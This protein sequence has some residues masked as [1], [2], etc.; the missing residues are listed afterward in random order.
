MDQ[1]PDIQ[2]GQRIHVSGN[3]ALVSKIYP[4]TAD[5][6]NTVEI[7]Y[8]LHGSKPTYEDAHWIDGEWRFV[9]AGQV[10][11]Y[12]DRVPR[13]RRYVEALLESRLGK[14]SGVPRKERT[15][16]GRSMTSSRSYRTR[17]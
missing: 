7:V 16:R 8:L 14:K 2:T 5:H 12:A 9:S 17:R 15:G 4:D 3:E 13:L 6:K 10:G 11:D 1:R